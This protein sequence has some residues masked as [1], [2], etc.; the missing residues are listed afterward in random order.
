MKL[1]KEKLITYKIFIEEISSHFKSD[2]DIIL[3][4]LQNVNIW[5]FEDAYKTLHDWIDNTIK[6]DKE[7]MRKIIDYEKNM[8]DKHPH[9]LKD[10]NIYLKLKIEYYIIKSAI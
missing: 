10:N 6:D 9:V 5:D 7:F 1:I 4:F 2:K 3:A 8:R